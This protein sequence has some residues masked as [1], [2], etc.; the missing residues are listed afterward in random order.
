MIYNA[1][2][3]ITQ[4]TG[5]AGSKAYTSLATG[6]YAL[7]KPA[8]NESLAIF[9]DLPIGESYGFTILSDSIAR[10]PPEALFTV[11]GCDSGEFSVNDTFVVNHE[12]IK[13]KLGGQMYH[14]GI[15]VRR[16]S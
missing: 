1:I 15:C 9:Q 5:T 4:M 11:T 6:V 12:G 2:L 8:S 16:R 13:N 14:T 7:I 10:I 3:T